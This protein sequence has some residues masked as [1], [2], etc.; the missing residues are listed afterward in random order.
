MHARA[1]KSLAGRLGTKADAVADDLS[2]T[3]GQ[4]GTAHPLLMLASMLEN[5]GPDELIALVHLA[6]GA[7][8][9]ILKTTA[10]IAGWRRARTVEAQIAAAADLPYGRFLAWREMLVPEP[11]RRPEPQRV[12]STAA[13]RSGDFKFGF[14]GSRDTASG[15]VHLPPARISMQGGAV[16]QME[17]APIAD[18]A[19]TIATFT[20]DRLAYSPSP[21]IVFALVDFEGG[22]RFP[23]ELTDVDADALRVGDRVE[24][25]FR[26]LFT[27]DGIHDYFWKARP[28][29]V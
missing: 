26:R 27:A 24:M 16:D 13:W 10:A 23:V 20:V 17:P 3:V 7:E 12:S 29:R 14:V 9:I 6:D 1:A 22:G 28:I 4:T 18:R 5:A 15:A 8:V 21:P 19:G 25:T 2:A 11:P